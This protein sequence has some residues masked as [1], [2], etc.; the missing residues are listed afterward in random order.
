MLIEEGKISK[1]ELAQ[2]QEVV[3]ALKTQVANKD[4]LVDLLQE[5]EYTL[6]SL[7]QVDEEVIQNL[8]R[9]I[10]NQ[11]KIY[12]MQSSLTKKYKNHRWLFAI[13]ASA[14]TFLIA[15]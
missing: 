8:Q 13:L 2:T 12:G 4:S 5:K 14:I 6:L 3:K 1:K 7:R 10:D 11:D 9:Q 15:R